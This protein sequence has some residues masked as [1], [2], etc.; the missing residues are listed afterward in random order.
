MKFLPLVL[1][2][3]SCQPAAWQDRPLGIYPAS[4]AELN[5]RPV[6]LFGLRVKTPLTKGEP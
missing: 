1:L 3:H 6:Q 5:G 2:L 4:A